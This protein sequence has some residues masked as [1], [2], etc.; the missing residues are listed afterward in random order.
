MARVSEYWRPA[1]LEEALAR[2]DSPG[3]VLVGGGT[4]VNADQS[5]VPISV[6]DLQALSI[7]G[8][9]RHGD[10]L[11][12]GAM[13]TLQCLADTDDVP[14]A[15]RDAARR[16]E[17]STLRNM[18]TVG[19]CIATADPSSELLACF[20]VHDAQVRLVGPDGQHHIEMAAL[21]ADRRQLA[22]R[23]IV[24]VHIQTDGVTSV[25]RTGRTRGD[26][27]IVAA[28]ARRAA[29]RGRR[30]ALTGVAV[31]PVLVAATEKA[32]DDL[33][34]LATSAVRA[35]TAAPLRPCWQGARSMRSADADRHNCQ[36]P[37]AAGHLRAR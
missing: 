1:T 21:L 20:L 36:R 17:P 6:V 31:T 37:C 24:A 25:A 33:T 11:L 15:I 10:G 14:T 13:A 27:P 34:P 12:V 9:S 26:R 22:G 18:A 19:G 3:A 23:I 35:S 28:V 30:L 4:K 16:E 2:L 8:I 5:F 32:A 29:D 7:D